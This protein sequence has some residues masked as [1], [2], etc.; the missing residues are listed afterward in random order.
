MKNSFI[1]LLFLLT[2]LCQAQVNITTGSYDQDFGTANIT[3]WTNNST[4]PGWYIS[5]T[6]QGNTNLSASANSYNSGGF[7]AYN[8]GGDSKIGSR[9]SGSASN[10]YYGVV[11]R[12][13]TGQA[14]RSIRVAYTGYQM[15]L[16]TNGNNINT[17]AFDY[18]VSTT[19]PAITAGGGTGVTAL[20]FQQ[21]QNSSTSGGNQLN[22]YPCTQSRALSS[23]IPVTI[24]NNSYVMLRWRDVDDS[25]NDHHMAIDNIQVDFDMT[26][27]TCAVFLPVELM[28]FNATYNGAEVNLGWATASEKNNSHFTVERSHNGVDFEE[29]VQ[30]KGMSAHTGKTVYEQVDPQPLQGL[31]YYRLRQTDKDGTASYSAIEAVTIEAASKVRIFPNPTS[32]GRVTVEAA[33]GALITVIDALGQTLQETLMSDEQAELVLPLSG[34]GMYTILVNQGGQVSAHRILSE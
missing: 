25:G 12:N 4:Y 17:I 26:G 19:A 14:I 13:M 33:K 22:W 18:V 31:S 1:S 11:L 10:L 34:K 27:G 16:A 28:Y 15:S 7:Y 6:F 21:L 5:G 20:N 30:V 8:C 23:C 9:A 29:L 24:A 2:A 32:S 3:S